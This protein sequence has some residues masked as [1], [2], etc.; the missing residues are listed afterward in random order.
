MFWTWLV[1]LAFAQALHNRDLGLLPRAALGLV[2]LTTMYVAFG[3][4]NDWKSG[5]VPAAVGIVVILAISSWRVALLMV[6]VGLIPAAGFVQSMINS[7]I[8]SYSTRSKPG[9]YLGQIIKVNPVL[10]LGPANYYW[11][12]PLFPIRGYFV[13]FNSHSQYIDLVAQFGVIGF[14]AFLWFTFE[15]GRVVWRLWRSPVA[16]GFAHAYVYSAIGGFVATLAA[17]FLGGRLFPFF[18]N[19][20]LAGFRASVLPWIFMGGLVALAAMKLPK[21]VHWSAG[22]LPIWQTSEGLAKL[23]RYSLKGSPSPTARRVAVVR[24]SENDE[25]SEVIC[26]A[27]QTLG[28]EPM[29]FASDGAV[30][31]SAEIVFSFA[32]YGNFMALVDHLGDLPIRRRPALIHWNTEGIPDLHLPWGYVYPV[33]RLRSWFGRMANHRTWKRSR[34]LPGSNT[35]CCA[36]VMSVTIIRPTGVVFYR[37]LPIRRLSMPRFIASTDCPQP[38]SPGVR[39][40][41]GMRI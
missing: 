15:I 4:Q 31:A 27:L 23:C 13:S 28:H 1:V 32:P 2:A 20:G 33:S 41:P 30:P 5:W 24:W 17:G 9:R 39:R 16:D 8:Y 19:V 6:V 10:G 21:R 14:L 35:A 18:Y 34:H 11:Y 12:T 40:P 25:L 36:F 7:D 26:D 22:T 3:L 38:T 37:P 29:P